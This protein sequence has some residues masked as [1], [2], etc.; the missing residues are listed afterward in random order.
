MGR[1]KYR[2]EGQTELGSF[3]LEL[4]QEGSFGIGDFLL[5]LGLSRLDKRGQ[6]L[7]GHVI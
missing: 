5:A 1:G 3:F 4:T 7:H 6:L 2:V